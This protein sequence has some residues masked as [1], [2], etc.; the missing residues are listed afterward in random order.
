M[1][2]YGGCKMKGPFLFGKTVNINE[3]VQ[4]EGCGYACL[5]LELK[6][7]VYRLNSDEI[8]LN[9]GIITWV[10]DLEKY[11]LEKEKEAVK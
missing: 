4:N 11:L 5:T 3:D 6:F 9:Q 7:H 8:N 1:V 10:Q 2:G